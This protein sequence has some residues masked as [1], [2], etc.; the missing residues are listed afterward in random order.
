MWSMIRSNAEMRKKLA[1]VASFVVGTL[2]L[3]DPNESSIASILGVV[4]G[5]HAQPLS[6]QAVADYRAEFAGYLKDC[7]SKRLSVPGLARYPQSIAEFLRAEPDRYAPGEHPVECPITSAMIESGRHLASAC[8][9]HGA[10]SMISPPTA[11]DTEVASIIGY[12]VQ[13]YHRDGRK[14]E[15]YTHMGVALKHPIKG[16]CDNKFKNAY[17]AKDGQEHKPKGGVIDW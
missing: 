7:R 8:D 1:S 4:F 2:G 12:G 6:Y 14:S 15:I 16:Y 3:H 5:A 11:S 13:K 17:T 10:G 9:T